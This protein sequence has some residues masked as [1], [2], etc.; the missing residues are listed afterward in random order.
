MIKYQTEQRKVL[1]SLFEKDGHRTYSAHDIISAIPDAGISLSAI[2]RNLKAL[3]N[4]GIISKINDPK[5]AEARYHY[6]NKQD[7]VGVVHLKCENCNQIYHLNRHIS[8][9]IFALAKD[10]LNFLLNKS[11]AFLYG[12]CKNCSQINVV[13]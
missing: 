5:Q 7:C 12:K 6:L 3:E 2:Y 1:I 9:M 10:E 4:D 13:I 11:G 8:D